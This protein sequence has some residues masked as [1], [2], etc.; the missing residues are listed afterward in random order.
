M[1][2]DEWWS[3][4]KACHEEWQFADKEALLRAAFNGGIEFA[5][6]TNPNAQCQLERG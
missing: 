2:F 4:F 5:T 1:D 3:E 6:A